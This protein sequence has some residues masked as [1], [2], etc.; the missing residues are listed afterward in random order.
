MW[1]MMRDGVAAVF[2]AVRG[3]ELVVDVGVRVHE[4][5]VFVHA[6]RLDA[7]FV[8]HLGATEPGPPAGPRRSGRRGRRRGGRP[9]SSPGCAACRRVGSDAIFSSSAGPDLGELVARPRGHRRVS[10]FAAYSGLHMHKEK[11][12][13]GRNKRS[14]S[15][16]ACRERPAALSRPTSMHL[17]VQLKTVVA[18]Q[19]CMMCSG[20]LFLAP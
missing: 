11:Q 8:A 3:V 17:L 6:T 18:T 20:Y 7:A 1:L 10:F 5:D 12:K 19:R 15:G 14:V 13:V 2:R 9:K 4:G 16:R